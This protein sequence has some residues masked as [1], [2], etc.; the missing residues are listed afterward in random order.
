MNPRYAICVG[1]AL[2]LIVVSVF[3]DPLWFMIVAVGTAMNGLAVA[4]NGWKMPV[5]RMQEE[6]IRHRP[7][8]KDTRYKCLSDVIPVGIGTASVGDFLI[9]GGLLASYQDPVFMDA[10][11]AKETIVI[12]LSWWALGWFKGFGVTEKW[13]RE[14]RK[15]MRKQFAANFLI[16]MWLMAFGNLLHLKSC[17]IG[18]MRAHAESVKKEIA[19][20]FKVRP[21]LASA[22]KASP[23]R[24]LG[25]LV[26][27]P[28]ELLKRLK[29]ARDKEK[30]EDLKLLTMGSSQF[31]IFTSSS[32][33]GSTSQYPSPVMEPIGTR[34]GP[35]C[36]ITCAVHHTSRYDVEVTPDLCRANRVPPAA[37]YVEGWLEQPPGS[38]YE[39]LVP[40]PGPAN[41]Q[42]GFDGYKLY[43]K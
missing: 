15:E 7:M 28:K 23:S 30:S 3:P 42:G 25:R 32:I 12:A 27:P 29:R 11:Y 9:F 24:S 10:L 31:V 4:A 20:D 38:G 33:A 8:T 26:D 18:A 43:W 40:W 13:T 36:R 22:V 21:I 17:G 5:W 1:L 34:K 39:Y 37:T 6:I 35:F 41:G 16:V 14:E 2:D 19:A